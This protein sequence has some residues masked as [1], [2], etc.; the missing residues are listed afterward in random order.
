MGIGINVVD[1]VASPGGF[2]GKVFQV[3]RPIVIAGQ[4]ALCRRIGGAFL[5]LQSPLLLGAVDL[6]EVL[7]GNLAPGADAGF[8]L[9]RNRD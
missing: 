9:S 7:L 6:R 1:D 5:R 8:D 2:G 4:I 3:A